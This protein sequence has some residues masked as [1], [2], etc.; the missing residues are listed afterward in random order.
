MHFFE[1]SLG[2]RPTR[3]SERITKYDEIKIIKI[4]L[5][6]KIVVFLL[7]GGGEMNVFLVKNFFG[8]FENSK[9]YEEC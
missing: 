8:N 4:P 9:C 5:S 6:L 2:T 1:R 3:S 7:C